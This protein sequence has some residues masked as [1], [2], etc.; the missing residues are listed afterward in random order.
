M[1]KFVMNDYYL[2]DSEG[3]L[4][5]LGDKSVDLIFT[6]PP[7]LSQSIWKDDI[8]SH[9]SWQKKMMNQFTRIIKDTGFIVISQTDRKYNGYVLS[10]HYNYIKF[11]LESDKDM[12]I[13]D[14]KII[15]RNEVGKKDMYHFTYQYMTIFTRKGKFH[16]GGEILRDI[17]VDK[18]VKCPPKSNQYCWSDELCSLIIS[19]FSKEG[20]LVID[21][22]A[23]AGPVLYAAKKLKRN[24]WG[25]EICEEMYN[26]NFK[27][28]RNK[29]DV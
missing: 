19:T 7:D 23:A 29:L 16:R 9:I 21:P 18:Q 6:S 1:K 5:E 20:D 17:I 22:F 2:G 24:Y 4:E 11:I 25:A 28:F 3:V 26:E 15:V 14:E 13:K 10:N 12:N 8:E 27:Y